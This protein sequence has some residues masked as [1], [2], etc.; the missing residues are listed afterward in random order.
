MVAA[1]DPIVIMGRSEDSKWFFVGDGDVAGFVFEDRIQW[2]GEMGRLP[3]FTHSSAGGG[4]ATP[5]PADQIT[6]LSFDLWPL[7]E[8]RPF[9][10]TPAGKCSSSSRD[11][12]AMAFTPISGMENRFP[13]PRQTAPS[14]PWSARAAP[15]PAMVGWKLAAVYGRKK[16][17]SSKRQTAPKLAQLLTLRYNAHHDTCKPNRSRIIAASSASNGRYHPA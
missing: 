11:T 5:K 7:P 9:A 8:I 6:P 1:G 13:M 2:Y 12:A 15:S 3:I 17:C 16:P 4:S 10:P 14:T